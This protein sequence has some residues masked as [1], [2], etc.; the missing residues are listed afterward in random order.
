MATEIMVTDDEL[1]RM[2][3]RGRSPH[4]IRNYKRVTKQFRELIGKPICDVV[5]EDVQTYAD[6]LGDYGPSTQANY[7]A[8]VKSLLSFANH[9]GYLPSNVGRSIRITREFYAVADDLSGR[10]PD[11]GTIYQMFSHEP[12]DRNRLLL[13]TMYYSGCRTSE[14]VALT[15]GDLLPDSQGGYLMVGIGRKRRA[16]TLPDFLRNEL[17]DE[18]QGKDADAPMFPSRK[19]RNE[20]NGHLS[21]VQVRDIVK[22]AA[23]RAH[24]SGMQVSRIV[25][26]AAGRVATAMDITPHSLRHAH[27]KHS[28]DRGAPLETVAQTLGFSS[29]TMLM[30]YLKIDPGDSSG[31]Y[32][33]E[34]Y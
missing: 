21:G 28:L 15:W 8:I 11:E 4:T 17:L 26:E 33:S 14:V 7:L 13:M 25:H 5:Y 10:I 2:W 32:L 30:K 34:M 12:N 9:I 16:V 18:S 20:S 29:T 3:L 31:N 1:I 27:A 24:L 19:F 22:Q 23:R 6:C